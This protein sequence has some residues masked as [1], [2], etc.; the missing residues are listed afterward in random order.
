[1]AFAAY[2]IPGDDEVFY[3]FEGEE[4]RLPC[5]LSAS[6]GMEWVQGFWWFFYEKLPPNPT[7]V[8][9]TSVYMTEDPQLDSIKTIYDLDAELNTE[10]RDEAEHQAAQI[11]R[12]EV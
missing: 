8:L 6:E 11:A 12:R 4:H 5:P 1:M 3:A 10:A 2:K 7:V 9:A